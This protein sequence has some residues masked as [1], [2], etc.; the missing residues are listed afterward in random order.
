MP[1]IDMLQQANEAYDELKFRK[2]RKLFLRVSQ[3]N[4]DAETYRRMA[5]CEITRKKYKLVESY[6]RKAVEMDPG[7]FKAHLYL[8]TGLIGLKR[9][10]E[11]EQVAR[12][13]IEL[14]EDTDEKDSLPSQAYLNL[15]GL[16][17][18]LKRYDEA[19]QAIETAIA[20]LDDAEDKLFESI[21]NQYAQ[22]KL[23]QKDYD[24]AAMYAQKSLEFNPDGS[25]PHLV[26]T[27]ILNKQEKF[28]GALEELKIA[29]RIQPSIRL[30]LL[31]LPKY[32]LAYRVLYLGF[33]T[34]L[35][36]LIAI[37]FN[38]WLA[39][40]VFVFGGIGTFI[41]GITRKKEWNWGYVVLATMATW[42]VLTLIYLGIVI[43]GVFW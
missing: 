10:K 15:S 34:A 28:K 38:A 13:T 37:I 12:T 18:M 35:F 11:A 30:L 23:Y 6:A 42:M 39:L 31:L 19:E 43:F 29:Y 25:Y 8:S 26:M 5:Y 24:S 14:S 4:W 20:L 17:T 40:I 33:M 16:F 1:D 36:S 41:Y 27:D 2:A 21:W 9:Y 32:L 3:E 22:I 7:L